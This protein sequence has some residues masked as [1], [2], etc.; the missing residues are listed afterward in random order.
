MEKTSRERIALI[1]FLVLAIGAGFV[2]FGYIIAGH[3]WNIVSTNLDD[4][5]G[6]MDGY[7]VIT[8]EGTAD[9][10]GKAAAS[11]AASQ[12]TAGESSAAAASGDSKG[13]ASG[14][15]A[16]SSNDSNGAKDTLQAG[17][18]SGGGSGASGTTAEGAKSADASGAAS[19]KAS[20][21]AT[22]GERSAASGTA[23]SSASDA[24]SAASAPLAGHK[25][26]K[27]PV[28]LSDVNDLYVGK[29]ATILSI[30][31]VDPECYSEGSIL[32]RGGK[33]YGIFSLDAESSRILVDEKVKYLR[34][35]AVDYVIAVVPENSML[36]GADG[37][38]IVISTEDADASTMG[39][40]KSGTFFVGAPEVGAIGAILISPSNVVSAKTISEL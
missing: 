36:K 39:E 14:S 38:D 12:A 40:T 22:E 13:A 8:Y 23:Q 5:F 17:E 7:T 29:G 31:T 37:I 32:M 1:V 4:T 27:E 10:S 28:A 16:G 35:Q 18:A 21:N 9:E 20:A 30:D 19:A 15:S 26:E 33:R 34:D 11:D 3:S 2:L 6:N 24:G 25:K